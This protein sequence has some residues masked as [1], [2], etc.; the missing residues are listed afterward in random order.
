VRNTAK[1]TQALSIF[2]YVYHMVESFYLTEE[3]S[4]IVLYPGLIT[5]LFTFADFSAGML[6]G[7]MSDWV[8]RRPVLIMGLDGT[9]ISMIL[10]GFASKFPTALAARALGGMLNGNAGVL[11]TTVADIVT[12]KEHQ[13]RAYSI[14]PFVC[15][16]YP[17]LFFRHTVSGR[18]PFSVVGLFCLSKLIHHMLLLS[19]LGVRATK[20]VL[21]SEI[22][23]FPIGSL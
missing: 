2:P 12:S 17:S 6:C 4:K 7:R 10:L 21:E 16:K 14:M 15:D 18:F 19:G 22:N 8:C 23:K 3:D 20:N 1:V 13:S 11:Q 5:S 9:V